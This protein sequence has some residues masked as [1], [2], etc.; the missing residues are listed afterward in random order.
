MKSFKF[1]PVVFCSIAL[2]NSAPSGACMI[3]VL[4]LEKRV[5]ESNAIFVGFA[6]EIRETKK[7]SKHFDHVIEV[8]VKK[9]FK[10]KV[11][12][13]A[14]VYFRQH[15]TQKGIDHCRVD[16][17]SFGPTK[18]KPFKGDMLIFAKEIDGDLVTNNELFGGFVKLDEKNEN[19]SNVYGQED[20]KRLPELVKD[21]S[22]DK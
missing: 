4:P 1:L 21:G 7:K 8:K 9:V 17:A 3:A 11:G 12:E 18:K 5:Q 13:K 2:F 16:E 19:F 10:G 22:G 14:L 6:E 20:L 15:V